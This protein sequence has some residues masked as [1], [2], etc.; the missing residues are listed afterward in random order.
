[1]GWSLEHHL[2]MQWAIHLDMRMEHCWDHHW[3]MHLVIHL[4]QQLA[5]L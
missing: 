1:M 3:G 2:E 4:A 5:S